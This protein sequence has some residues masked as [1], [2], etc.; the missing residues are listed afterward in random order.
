MFHSYIRSFSQLTQ[1]IIGF[2]S[3]RVFALTGGNWFLA[4]AVC[5]LALGP[6]IMNFVQYSLF[7]TVIHNHSLSDRFSFIQLL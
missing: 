7:D 2:A 1:S 6:S 5:V 3:L 4:P